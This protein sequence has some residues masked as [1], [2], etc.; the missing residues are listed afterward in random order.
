ML[1]H[2][3][4]LTLLAYIVVTMGACGGG[5]DF[6]SIIRD[7]IGYLKEITPI[8]EG[9]K[10]ANSFKKA[11]PRIRDFL[12][13]MDSLKKKKEKL[14]KPPEDVKKSAEMKKL[15]GEFEKALPGFSRATFRLG[16]HDDLGKDT[17]ELVKKLMQSLVI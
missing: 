15:S 1:R 2:G 17:K 10:D 6:E 14:G 7:E 4:G 12:K 3:S 11:E 13:K 9:V 5:G 16:T 8:L